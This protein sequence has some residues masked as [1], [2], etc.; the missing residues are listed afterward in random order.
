MDSEQLLQCP[1]DKS[2]Q[3]RPC[4]FP[5]HLVKCRENNKKIA[6]ELA[7]CPYNA[8]HRVPRQ[9]L[10][11]HMSSCENKVSQ[12]LEGVAY[13]STNRAREVI[14]FQCPP[15]QED[16][17]ADADESPAPPFVFGTSHLS[18]GNQNT[19]YSFYKGSK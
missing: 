5:Y 14:A 11:L 19:S 1:Y 8:R 10:S 13:G 7:T 3:I 17:E 4:R 18:Q 9:E 6:K 16:W 15:S 12:E 2:H